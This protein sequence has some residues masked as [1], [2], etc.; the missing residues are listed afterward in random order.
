MKPWI[1]NLF[2]LIGIGNLVTMGLATPLYD[3]TFLT[4]LA[5]EVFSTVGL[6]AIG[7]WG[8]MYI[9][10]AD[11]YDKVPFAVLIIALEK[12]FYGFLWVPWI[13]ANGLNLPFIFRCD[14]IAALA[15]TAWGPYDL[16][17]FVFFFF[18]FLSVRRTAA[19]QTA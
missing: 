17:S 12:L 1:R 10:L 6:I 18:V 8:L 19:G 16:V 15:F 13:L 9:A 5:P 3:H 2:Y 7:L 11:V 4:S 14:P